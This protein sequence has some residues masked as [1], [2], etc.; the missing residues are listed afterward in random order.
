ML[1]SIAGLIIRVH[2]FLMGAL[3]LPYAVLQLCLRKVSQSIKHRVSFEAR[4][5]SSSSAALF[6]RS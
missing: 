1:R 5:F 4:R 3:P 2:H 6:H